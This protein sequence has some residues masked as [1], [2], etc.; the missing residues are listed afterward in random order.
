MNEQKL[1][2]ASRVEN[3]LRFLD[4]IRE[5]FGKDAGFVRGYQECL[6]DLGLL[7]TEKAP[8]ERQLEGDKM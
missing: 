1:V 7:E 5:G 6:E 8:S 3:A 2:D 4:H